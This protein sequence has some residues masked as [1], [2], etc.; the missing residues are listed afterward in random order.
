MDIIDGGD[1]GAWRTGQDDDFFYR[2]VFLRRLYAMGGI[3]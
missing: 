3:H 2:K 1:G